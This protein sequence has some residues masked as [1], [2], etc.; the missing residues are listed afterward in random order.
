MP[1]FM[2]HL[3]SVSIIRCS[4]W[5]FVWFEALLICFQKEIFRIPFH[6]NSAKKS[7]WSG[8]GISYHLFSKRYDIDTNIR[9]PTQ[10]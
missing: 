9:L 1:R 5:S 2:R 6:R 8:F 7:V 3:E 4:I 10:T